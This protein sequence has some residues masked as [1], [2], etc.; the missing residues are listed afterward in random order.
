M[1]ECQGIKA[2]TQQLYSWEREGG[3]GGMAARADCCLAEILQDINASHGGCIWLRKIMEEKLPGT[4]GSWELPGSLTLHDLA[5]GFLG[6]S[7]L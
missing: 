3:K 4:L 7:V 6:S 2:G 5:P 1:A